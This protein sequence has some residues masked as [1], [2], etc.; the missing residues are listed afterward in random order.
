M[1]RLDRDHSPN[2]FDPEFQ[3]GERFDINREMFQGKNRDDL[4][5][6]LPPLLRGALKMIARNHSLKGFAI[7]ETKYGAYLKVMYEPSEVEETQRPHL[8]AL[9]GLTQMNLMLSG[10]TAEWVDMNKR[11]FEEVETEILE[12]IVKKQ[13]QTLVGVFRFTN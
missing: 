8:E 13:D 11:Q 1:K 2:P 3:I 7:A 4:T 5:K 6:D 12:Q 10:S 9:R